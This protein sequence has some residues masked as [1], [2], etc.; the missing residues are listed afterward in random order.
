MRGDNIARAARIDRVLDLYVP[1]SFEEPRSES[2]S[3]PE[4]HVSSLLTDIHHHCD[5]NGISWRTV[6]EGAADNYTLETE[7]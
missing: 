4:A 6:L 7:D 1:M 5:V 2:D 3:S